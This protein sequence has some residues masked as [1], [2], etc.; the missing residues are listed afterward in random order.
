MDKDPFHFI[1]W[2]K[3][4]LFHVQNFI[5]LHL[6]VYMMLHHLK[7]FNDVKHILYMVSYT[8][9]DLWKKILTL[10]RVLSISSLSQFH[11]KWRWSYTGKIDIA[12]LNHNSMFQERAWCKWA[13]EWRWS[14]KE[15]RAQTERYIL[16]ND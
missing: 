13:L 7:N 9:L 4:E 11:L 1:K 3:D 6:T 15:F 16:R 8:H 14:S 10:K 2:N 5:L 12:S